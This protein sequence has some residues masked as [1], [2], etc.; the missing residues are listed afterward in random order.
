MNFQTY[1]HA[2]NETHFFGSQ[3]VGWLGSCDGGAGVI[4]LDSLSLS[5]LLYLAVGVPIG[6]PLNTRNGNSA[7]TRLGKTHPKYLYALPL[8]LPPLLPQHIDLEKKM[9][10]Q[11]RASGIDIK[12]KSRNFPGTCRNHQ[13]LVSRW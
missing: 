10:S 9:G 12:L 8:P 11:A 2:R 13:H 4:G 1:I 5:S 7:G 6:L 3:L